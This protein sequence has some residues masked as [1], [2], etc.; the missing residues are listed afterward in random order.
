VP[1]HGGQPYGLSGERQSR[2]R[3]FKFRAGTQI[4]GILTDLQDDFLDT[5]FTDLQDE[6]QKSV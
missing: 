3:S 4:L 1:F 6:I 5:D 2:K